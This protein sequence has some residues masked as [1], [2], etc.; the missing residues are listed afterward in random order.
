MSG[1]GK[2][3]AGEGWGSSTL[4]LWAGFSAAAGGQR[5]PCTRGSAGGGGRVGHP[6]DVD[7]K[8]VPRLVPGLWGVGLH[9]KIVPAARGRLAGVWIGRSGSWPAVWPRPPALL[10]SQ[11]RAASG[12]GRSSSR[13]SGR[14]RAAARWSATQTGRWGSPHGCCRPPAGRCTRR[15]PRRRRRGAPAPWG[16]PAACGAVQGRA[17]AHVS[18]EAGRR[19]GASAW[20]CLGWRGAA[21]G[22]LAPHQMSI[23]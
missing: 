5:P 12:G 22:A 18:R 2:L 20:A 15:Q 1:E 13:T 6:V 14:A 11:A 7:G 4:E 17:R 8:H 21:A 23:T 3:G 10:P 16:R 19:R 9:N